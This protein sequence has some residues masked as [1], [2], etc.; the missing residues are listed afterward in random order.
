MQARSDGLRLLRLMNETQARGSDES[1][2]NP[3]LATRQAEPD[4]AP[5]ATRRRCDASLRR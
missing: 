5:T 1:P 4:F 3:P 2:V